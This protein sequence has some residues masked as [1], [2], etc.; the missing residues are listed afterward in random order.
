MPESTEKL[1]L[2]EVV[3]SLTGYEEIEIEKQFG[4]DIEELLENKPRAGLRAAVFI[5]A[6]R[7][8]AALPAAKD[9]AMKLSMRALNDCFA[10]ETIELDP[11]DPETEQGKDGTPRD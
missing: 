8:G 5:I 11:D 9:E 4:D 7:R 3:E 6:R 2:E 10:D 1:S